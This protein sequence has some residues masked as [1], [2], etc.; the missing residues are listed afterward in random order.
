[1]IMIY[2]ISALWWLDNESITFQVRSIESE[3]YIELKDSASKSPR[4]ARSRASRGASK[5]G[6]GKAPRPS[7]RQLSG[8]HPGSLFSCWLG[9]VADNVWF[10]GA[11]GDGLADPARSPPAVAGVGG[12]LG[13]AWWLDLA[14]RRR[15]ATGFGGAEAGSKNG[16]RAQR[17]GSR[18]QRPCDDGAAAV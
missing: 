6:R 1:M 16:V 3:V 7:Q 15:V 8:R 18:A 17:S 5:E 14:G 9:T 2:Y 10:S 12:G 11:L 13:G 4:V